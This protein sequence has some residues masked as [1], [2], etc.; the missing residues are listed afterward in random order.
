VECEASAPENRAG[1]ARACPVHP[2]HVCPGHGLAGA[3]EPEA[4]GGEP[5]GWPRW[6]RQRLEQ[7]RDPVIVFAQGY[8]GICHLAE[9]SWLLGVNSQ[10]RPPGIGTPPHILA[11]YGLTDQRCAYIGISASTLVTTT[12]GSQPVTHR[13]M[14]IEDHYGT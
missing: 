7:T 11:Q 10:E 3:C 1:G 6:R 9:S 12:V 5:V 8:Y 13:C 4:R 14:K 2:A